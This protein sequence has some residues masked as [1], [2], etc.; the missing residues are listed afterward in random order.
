M[1][2][3]IEYGLFLAKVVTL[4]AAFALVLVLM[5]S[6]RQQKRSGEKGQL[7]VKHVNEAFDQMTL[8]LNNAMLSEDAQKQ[9]E[10]DEKRRQKAARKAEKAAL[11]KGDQADDESETD[12]RRVF[13]LDFNGDIEASAVENLREEVSAVLSVA[14]AD[15]EVIVRLE[16]AGGVVH[17]YGL[18]ASQLK[19]IRERGVKLT[20]AVD[21]V[22]A[23]GGYMMACIADQIIAAPFAVLGSI[24]VVAQIPNFNRLLKSQNIDVEMHTAGEYKRTLTMLGENTEAG[25]E[26]F[27]EELED[28]H[29]LF[30]TFVA[31][32]RSKVDIAAV[33]TGEAWYG[34]RALERQLVDLLMTSDEYV[35]KKLKENAVYEVKYE[36]QEGK[37]EQAMKKFSVLSARWP[38]RKKILAQ[39]DRF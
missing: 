13:V 33:G 35:I 17:G 36:I 26:K 30:K 27:L 10:K 32:N 12:S 15:D 18:A 37:F 20:V 25:R 22:A 14:G 6:A 5:L 4:C 29:E 9:A 8:S 19:R 21:K 3:L 24:G 34:Q 11:K 38:A 28:V 39:L 2:F 16:S 1:E 7:L 31:E 23:S